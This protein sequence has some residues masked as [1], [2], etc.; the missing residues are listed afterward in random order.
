MYLRPCDHD[1][2]EP[3]PLGRADGKFRPAISINTKIPKPRS[4]D[5]LNYGRSIPLMANL[6]DLGRLS[7][8]ETSKNTEYVEGFAG[9]AKTGSHDLG[10]FSKREEQVLALH[11]QLEEL[12]LEIFLS[13]ALGNQP[14][15][16]YKTCSSSG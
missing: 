13:E 3:W 10:S 15:G 1:G 6:A 11:D 7:L 4:L 12:K 2:A 9:L 8:V 16:E 5:V 14:G